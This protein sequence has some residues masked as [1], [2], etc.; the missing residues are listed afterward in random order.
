MGE[1][2][3]VGNMLRKVLLIWLVFL[4][5]SLAIPP[6]FH[7]VAEPDG[8]MQLEYGEPTAEERV[9]VLDDNTDALLWRLRLIENAQDRIILAT[10]DFWDD[11]SGMDIMAA[12]LN[13]AGK[14]VQ[15]KLL[16]DGLGGV[17]RLGNSGHFRELTAHPNVEARFYNPINL[18]LPW[19]VNY[20]MH[21]K[22]LIADDSV[23]IL[24]G[25][26]TGDLFLGCYTGSCN[27]DRDV[28][29]Y[30]MEP[31]KGRSYCQLAERFEQVWDL[32]CCRHYEG[33]GAATTDLAEHYLWIRQEYPEAFQKTDWIA[34]T[35]ETDQLTLL[36]SQIGPHNKSPQLWQ[37]LT[38]KLQGEKEV[39]AVTPY[40]ICSREMY[41]DIRE[42]CE[43]GTE[44]LFTINAPENGA[45]PF[46]CT[47]YLNQKRRIL[48]TGAEVCEYWGAQS[49][50][51]KTFLIGDHT[52][53]VGSC[54]MDMR[55]MYLDTELML[56][57]ESAQINQ[58][59]REKAKTLESQSILVSSDGESQVGENY[60]GTE[61]APGKKL[62]YV[63]L[64]ILSLPF[65]YLL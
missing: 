21:D 17:W 60:R 37:S 46:G 55:S 61:L 39:L 63:V 23:Y 19:R 41:Q 51:T 45:N 47:D 20:R 48:G 35:Q 27:E 36:L 11:N 6:L 53:I 49:L 10:F 5:L 30:E 8:Q 3:S 29:V 22:Y 28:L 33:Y 56:V 57:I 38:K 42:L 24:G 15:V 4:A 43:E 12:L 13:A 58:E 2:K 65:R 64:R 62:A 14:G 59:L 9:L 40:I 7:R 50:H 26:N 16:I 31:G 34:N 25:R 52:S 44:I 1:G 54:N 32:S 18:L